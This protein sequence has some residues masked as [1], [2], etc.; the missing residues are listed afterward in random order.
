MELFSHNYVQYNSLLSWIRVIVA[1]RMADDGA[2]WSEIFARFNSG[3]YNN[4]WIVV[5]YNKFTPGQP[6][7]DGVLW[8]VEQIPGMVEG[9]DMTAAL[10]FG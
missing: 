5:D 9:A 8:I 4:Q 10:E 1:N 3:T 6:L 2:A 7:A